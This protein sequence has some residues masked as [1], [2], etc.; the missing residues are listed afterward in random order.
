MK[1]A[2]LIVFFFLAVSKLVPAQSVPD[3][4]SHSPAPVFKEYRFV[5]PEKAIEIKWIEYEKSKVPMNGKLA[6]DGNSILL[7]NYQT[8]QPVRVKVVLANGKSEEYVKS[9]C[10]IDPVIEAL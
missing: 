8:G 6:P 4:A 2:G 10:F 1:T 9:P 3:T 7:R 5:L